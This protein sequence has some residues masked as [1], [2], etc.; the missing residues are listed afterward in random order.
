MTSSKALLLASLPENKRQQWLASLSDEA[1]A[2]L[3]WEWSF[4]ARPEQLAPDGDWRTWLVLAGRG[5]DKTRCGAEWVRSQIEC[6]GAGRIALV[7]PTAADARDV[8]SE[9][10]S[11]VMAVCPPWNL[12]TYEPTK[13]RLTW[14]NGAVAIAYTADE[15]DRLRGPQHDAA[16]CDEIAAWRYPDAWDQL[17]F[18]LRLGLEPKTVVTTTP[19]P[20][21]LVR[22]L[23]AHESTVITKGST[24][25]NRENLAPDFFLDIVSRYEGTRLGRQE[26]HAEILDDVPGA[27]WKRDQLDANRVQQA[28]DCLRRIVVGVDPAVSSGENS[29]ETGIVVAGVDKKGHGYVLADRTCRESP[30]G[31]ARRVVRAYQEFN[32]DR[33][34]AEGNNGGDLVERVIRTVDESISYKKVHASRGKVTRAEPVA[35]L[36]E[37]GKVHHVGT[38]PHLEDQ[39]C[40]YTPQGYQGS[41]DRVDALCWAITQLMIDNP[42]RERLRLD[43]A[44]FRAGM[45]PS[46]WRFDNYY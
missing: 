24:Y 28:P 21:S 25:E 4:W 3:R 10:P 42:Y 26:I 11:G 33:V 36:Y 16:W 12:P 13:R 38:F 14:S 41:P 44:A 5:W 23:A 32:A 46:P 45:R 7:A 8:M 30:D 18:G 22:Q 9:G 17:R 34:V 37:Q 29:A 35:A 27:L 43:P 15:P 1:A 2:Q 19:R 31:W 6:G 40:T 39:Q 20:T